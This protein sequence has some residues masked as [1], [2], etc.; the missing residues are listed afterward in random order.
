MK[1]LLITGGCSFTAHIARE[2]L[3]WPW[4]FRG[5]YSKKGIW[6]ENV[7]E[8]ASGNGLIYRNLINTLEL[9]RKLTKDLTVAVMWSNPNRFEVLIDKTMPEFK[10]MY[11]DLHTGTGTTI[12]TNRVL[13]N[14][15][16]GTHDYANWLKSGGGF[17]IW[18]HENRYANDIHKNFLKYI[19]S[20]A[21][22]WHQTLEYIVHLQQYCE[23]HK[24]PII[25]FTWENIMQ[26]AN[27]IQG[28][29]IDEDKS[30]LALNQLNYPTSKYLWNMINWD[31]WWFHGEYGGLKEYCIDSG[32]PY[33]NGNHPCTDC[34]LNFA[35][36]IVY[37]LYKKAQQKVGRKK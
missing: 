31:N 12:F 34:Q 11:R 36:D 35:M 28:S 7:A 10:S 23:L 32:Y 5:V 17:G 1:E 24:I 25:N 3:A 4:H 21:Q 27:D 15:L 16:I 6:V 20:E 9:Q 33:L 37:P 8:M 30:K 22:Q 2:H 29:N 14:N 18:Q 13:N 26:G 19:H